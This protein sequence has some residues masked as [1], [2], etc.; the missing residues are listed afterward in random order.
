M[1]ANR[2]RPAHSR[3]CACHSGTARRDPSVSLPGVNSET[4]AGAIAHHQLALIEQQNA[5]AVAEAERFRRALADGTRR[6]ADQAWLKKEFPYFGLVPCRA[7]GLDFVLFH[8]NDDIV[9]WE[10]LWFGD[11]GYEPEITKTWV[12]WARDAGVVYDI[13]AYTGL[14]SVLAALANPAAEIHLWEPMDRTIERAQIN[15]RLNQVERQ[16]RLHDVAVSDSPGQVEINLYRGPNFLGT[17]NSIYDKGLPIQAVKQVRRV[18][19]DNFFPEKNPDLVKID[20]EGHELAAL[21]G[22]ERTIERARPRMIVEIWEHTRAETLRLLESWG[23]HCTP[24]EQQER[25]VMNFKC[26]SQ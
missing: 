7:T 26:L 15:L 22:M 24:F 3:S 2:L 23:Y 11:D 1:G 5:A 17:G 9:A 25:R 4:R 20:I 10:Y 14:M 12:E 19:V 8:A 18:V 6:R 21:R 13:G 16:V